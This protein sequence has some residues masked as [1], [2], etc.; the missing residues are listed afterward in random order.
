MSGGNSLTTGILY[1]LLAIVITQLALNVVNG[2]YEVKRNGDWNPLLDNTVG[3]FFT[4]DANIKESVRQLQTGEVISD[5]PEA[6]RAN[7]VNY[8][9][10]TIIIN[11]VYLG[12]VMFLLFRLFKWFANSQKFSSYY[13]VLIFAMV[14]FVYGLAIYLYGFYFHD[15]KQVPFSGIWQLINNYDRLYSGYNFFDVA[16][17]TGV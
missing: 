11:L 10:N 7:Y 5:I 14:I 15:V 2:I 17:N 8:L 4:W 1:G 16:K 6:Y 13:Q 12:A 3:I 9:R